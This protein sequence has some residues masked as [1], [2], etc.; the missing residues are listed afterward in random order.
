LNTLG[1]SLVDK[2]WGLVFGG[3]FH[4]TLKKACPNM[5]RCNPPVSPSTVGT[6]APWKDILAIN[7]EMITSG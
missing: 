5:R 7:F 4:P 6:H 1:K 3:Y 2:K